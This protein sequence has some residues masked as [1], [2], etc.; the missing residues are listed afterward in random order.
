MRRNTPTLVLAIVTGSS[1]AAS[2]LI[3]GKR[4]KKRLIPL[5]ALSNGA[6]RALR[7]ATGPGAVMLAVIAMAASAGTAGAARP[8]FIDVGQDLL[9]VAPVPPAVAAERRRERARMGRFGLLQVAP[10][11][12]GVRAFGRLDALLTGESARSGADIALDYVRAHR[13]VFGLDDADLSALRIV[14]RYSAA[15]IEQVRWAQSFRGITAIDTS[16]TA[17]LTATGRLVNVVGEPRHDLALRSVRPSIGP[18]AAV[19][20]AARA[21]GAAPPQ[22][23]RTPGGPERETTFAGGASAKLV[24]YEGGGPR[25]GWRMTLPIDATH[26]YDV[27]VDATSGKLQRRQNVV[28]TATA[29]IYRNYPGA[30]AGGSVETVSIDAYL[31]AGARR[32]IGPT[33]HTFTDED[34]VVSKPGDVPPAAGD[35]GPSGGGNWTYPVTNVGGCSPPCIWDPFDSDSWRV[36]RAADATQVHWFVSNFHDHLENTPAIGFGNAAGNFE[37]SDPVIAQS[38]DGADTDGGTPDANHINNAN[39]TTP[40]D[41]TSPRMQM[42]L[43]DA[44]PSAGSTGFDAAV[45]YHEYTHGLVART[46]VDATGARAIGGAQ[47]GAFNEGTSDLYAIDYLVAH[48]LETDTPGTPDVILAKYA[49]GELRSEPT[50]CLVAADPDEL[51]FDCGGGSTPHYGGYTYAD[52]GDVSF[53]GPEI[54]ADG[55]IWTQTMWQLRQALI[56]KHGVTAGTDHFRRLATNGMRLVPDNPT[57]LD[58]RNGV[59]QATLASAFP[60]DVGDVWDVF[61]ERGMGY[62]ASAT[63][64]GDVAPIADTSVPPPA[65]GPAGTVSGTITDATSGGPAAGVKVAFTGH[66][67]GIGPELSG[68]TN[69]SGSYAI[70]GVAPGTY[71]LL[72]ARGDGYVG[73]AASI[74]VAASGVTT[75]NFSLQ[76]EIASAAAG[77]RVVSFTGPD[78]SGDGCGPGGL[79]DQAPGVPWGTRLPAPREVVVG[80]QTP[81]RVTTIEID[82]SAGCGDDDNAS[83]GDYEVQI[84]PDGASFTSVSSG[85]FTAANLDRYNAIT[86]SSTPPGTRFLKLIAKSPQSDSGS[87]AEFVDVAEMR[88]FGTPA[89]APPTAPPP[90][91]PPPPPAPPPPAVTSL[92]PPPAGPSQPAP[93][94]RIAPDVTIGAA[95]IQKLARSVTVRVTCLSEPCKSRATATVRVPATR[96]RSA[97]TY[98][99]GPVTTSLVAKGKRTTLALRITS[100][101]RTAIRRALLAGKRVVVRFA[102]R[103]EDAAGNATTPTRAIRLKR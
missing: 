55:E 7:G 62:F 5:N 93:S 19:A 8:G 65:G 39:M 98:R 58:Q 60:G 64:A 46:I 94:D 70:T 36:N 23:L 80:L 24:I 28:D 99:L 66:D 17:N 25:L 47:G 83:L 31:N 89:L 22:A 54:H 50:D 30:P 44:G 10:R 87:G 35:V 68:T 3:D 103:V 26:I 20:G 63:D 100:S 40:A 81:T 27:L 34:D 71:P 86:L 76:R 56:A 2:K 4:I 12:G 52:F 96:G 18:S 49:F 67:S 6:T 32:L 95:T 48:A 69:A 84:S 74:P 90:P 59:L 11:S 73:E 13:E 61:A 85:T 88:A 92:P 51:D 82:P 9:A 41:G 15:G 57:F 75:R 33:A 1:V 91:P 37:G 72:R 53:A 29:T 38:M 78:F 79:I 14:R 42:Y 43:T 16:L 97:T 77:A 21:L 102:I 101:R 45:I